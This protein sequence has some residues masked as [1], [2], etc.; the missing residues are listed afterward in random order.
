MRKTIIAVF[1]NEEYLLPWWLNHHK[2]YFDHGILINYA[3]TDNSVNI[4]KDICP[5]WEI[6]E[7]R[8]KLFGA[9]EVDDE[10]T[11][12]ETRID[13]WKIC[14]NVTE[15]LVGDY[16]IL[17]NATTDNLVLPC[18]V[19]VDNQPDL[20]PDTNKSLVNQ[21][22]YGMHYNDGAS[23]IRRSRIIHSKRLYV[24][25]LGRHFDTPHT[26]E[27][28]VVLW[29]GFSPYNTDAVKR[30]LQIQ[31][32]IPPSDFAKGYG[33]QHNTNEEK[34]NAIYSGYLS[35]SKELAQEPFMLLN[36]A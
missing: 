3:S 12:I 33:T 8:N 6:V 5:T 30:K 10:V 24:Y 29:Y 14:L 25:P 26:T 17:N 13:G 36:N 11:D 1:Y 31:T 7:S 22:T 28:L 4:I 23:K 15:F 32:K 34:L 9:K 18:C 35:R 19:M 2:Q 16:S 27:D 21:K 20:I